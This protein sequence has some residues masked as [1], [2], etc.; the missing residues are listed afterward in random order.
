MI[1][2]YPKRMW[3][4]EKYL[5]P[6]MLAQGIDKD[7]II[8]YNDDKGLGNLKSCMDAFASVP[9]NLGG[10][11]HLQDDVCICKNFKQ[12]TEMWDRGIVCAFSSKMYD[13]EGRV[14]AVK[15]WQMWFSFPCIRIPNNFAH[16]C[17]IWVPKN[18]IGN[19]VY[20]DFW[21]N[22][23]NDDW[24]FRTFMNT[25]HKGE[26]ATNLAPNLVDHVDYLLGGGS[27]G[28]RK[29]PVRAQYWLDNDV[30]EKLE[31][32]ILKNSQKTT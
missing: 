32:K 29:E 26:I 24:A 13:G 19:P 20:K 14:G 15:L 7:D 25:M 9:D 23:V 18:I 31:K 28:T 16:E 1:H 6:S 4:V 5:V 30:V 12:M 21:K 10:T 22:G 2:A 3:Y 8:V 17:G 11:W 27:G